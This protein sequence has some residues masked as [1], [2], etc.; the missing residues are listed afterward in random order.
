MPNDSLDEGIKRLRRRLVTALRSCIEQWE[1]TSLS[2][3]QAS[4]AFRY[5]RAEGTTARRTA[6]G[7]CGRAST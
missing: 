2:R 5:H 7:F 3:V 6:F 1:A 4:D